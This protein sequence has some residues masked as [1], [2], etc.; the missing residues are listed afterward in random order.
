MPINLLS[1]YFIFCRDAIILQHS[2]NIVGASI[3]YSV[4]DNLLLVFNEAG[5]VGVIDV[6][7]PAS[8]VLSGPQPFQMAQPGVGAS[9]GALQPSSPHCEGVPCLL[10]ALLLHTT[11]Y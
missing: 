9:P 7:A 2:Y 4:C 11:V 8:S 6:D 10:H 1:R 3:Q 5:A